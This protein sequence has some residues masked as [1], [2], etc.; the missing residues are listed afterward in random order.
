MKL[1]TY[2]LKEHPE[3]ISEFYRIEDQG[4]PEFMHHDRVAQLHW[5]KLFTVFSYCQLVICNEKKETIG[6]GNSIPLYWNGVLD[7]L[8]LN[9]W[10]GI[11]QMGVINYKNNIKPNTLAALSVVIDTK[12]KKHGLSKNFILAFKKLVTEK[13]MNNFI[14][15]LRPSMKCKYPLI[16]IEK[17]VKWEDKDGLP[18]DP[19]LRTHYKLGGQILGIAHNSMKITG[20]VTQW[21]AWT[22]MKLPESGEYV[23]PGAL[24]PIKIDYK[25]DIGT[26]IEPNVWVKHNLVEHK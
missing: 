6:I 16:P 8:P 26:Y 11:I 25:N 7:T 14:I 4:Y 1:Y 9:G 24:V 3:F 13:S 19:W 10:D 18:F 5:K 21:E 12:F 23:I 20:T 2:N 17:Y 15:P 22:Q